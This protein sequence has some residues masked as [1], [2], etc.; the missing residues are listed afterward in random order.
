[1]SDI[2]S[3]GDFGPQ[4][5]IPPTAKKESDFHKWLESTSEI[6]SKVSKNS[7]PEG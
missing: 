4:I 7:Q 5:E 1:M 2:E 3:S 6:K